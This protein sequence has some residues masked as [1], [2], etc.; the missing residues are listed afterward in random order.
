[1]GEIKQM[2]QATQ[3]ELGFTKYEKSGA[4]HW[5]D[6]SGN[7]FVRNPFVLG[8]YKNVIALLKK[9]LKNDISS[10]KVLDMG[11]GDGALTY[12]IAKEDFFVS[13][14]DNSEI[15]IKFAKEK[16]KNLN[17]DFRVGNVYN[18]PYAK[19]EFDAVIASDVI[20]HLQDTTA[21]LNEI[22]RVVRIG[23]I[24]IISTPIRFTE[25]P[26]DKMHIFEFYPNEFRSVIESCFSETIFFES[27]PVFWME[28]FMRSNYSRILTNLLSLVKNPFENFNHKFR[29]N[30]LQ[31][32]VSFKRE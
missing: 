13:G 16:T 4:Y 32:S 1:M 20:E 28:F 3:P 19:N 30:S 26:L 7:I 27:H 18:S 17:I 14:I 25:N 12:L 6:I 21:F 5:Q 9:Y 23:G 10:K 8:R 29:Y 15:A 2:E 11:C 24:V 22:K 31:Y